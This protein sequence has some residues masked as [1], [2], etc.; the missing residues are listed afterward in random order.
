MC[1][2]QFA[3]N[4]NEY[5]EVAQCASNWCIGR[6]FLSR[7]VTKCARQRTSYLR[8]RDR[9]FSKLLWIGTLSFKFNV[10]SIANVW[11]LR[12]LCTKFCTLWIFEATD[13]LWCWKKQQNNWWLLVRIVKSSLKRLHRTVY[14]LFLQDYY[15]WLLKLEKEKTKIN[16]T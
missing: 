12:F 6:Y 3:I 16:K 8:E 11:Q 4:S 15:A 7:Y 10:P 9:E 13:C 1:V 2:L 14:R 5:S